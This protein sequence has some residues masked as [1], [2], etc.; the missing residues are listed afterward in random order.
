MPL[1]SPVPGAQV[2]VW[3]VLTT[4]CLLPPVASLLCLMSLHLNPTQLLGLSRSRVSSRKSVLMPPHPPRS[5]PCQAL[6]AP[7]VFPVCSASLWDSE[8]GC[9]CDHLG[10]V[11]PCRVDAQVWSGAPVSA[12]PASMHG[13]GQGLPSTEDGAQSPSG[14][15]GWWLHLH[16]HCGARVAGSCLPLVGT[17]AVGSA[18]PSCTP[19]PRTNTCIMLFPPALAQALS[20]SA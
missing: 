9:V 15:G 19:T 1:G 11:L 18:R 5:A 6:Q 20:M 8:C 16:R 7:Y 14:L 3:A 13:H 10:T 2:S 4:S 12:F 17:R